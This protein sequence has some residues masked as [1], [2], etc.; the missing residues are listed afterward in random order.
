M[1]G[2]GILPICA[3]L[4]DSS[5]SA[6]RG[7]HSIHGHAKQPAPVP[8]DSYHP[9]CLQVGTGPGP[10]PASDHSVLALLTAC[11]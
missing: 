11:P 1:L 7:W 6:R 2:A 8:V 9:G 10:S 3:V 5:F 4:H